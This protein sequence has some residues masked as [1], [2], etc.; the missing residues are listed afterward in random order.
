MV[1]VIA[2][3]LDMLAALIDRAIVDAGVAAPETALA[4]TALGAMLGGPVA[5]VGNRQRAARRHRL[6]T[7]MHDELMA[8]GRVSSLQ[9]EERVKRDLYAKDILAARVKPDVDNVFP[10]VRKPSVASPDVDDAETSGELIV[11]HRVRMKTETPRPA[12]RHVEPEPIRRRADLARALAQESADDA[13]V[14]PVMATV[15]PSRAA[16]TAGSAAAHAATATERPPAN[17]AAALGHAAAASLLAPSGSKKPS[18]RDR[19]AATSVE[20]PLAVEHD[21]ADVRASVRR[22]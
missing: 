18:F 21:V 12:P 8:T 9:D 3:T 5:S 1:G 16:V 20:P 10:F 13:A 14:S 7:V 17:A 4:T 6:I 11:L 15:L 2:D 19:R 22:T